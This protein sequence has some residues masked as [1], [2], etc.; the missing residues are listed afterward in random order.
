MVT[1][2]PES[3]LLDDAE[4]L[5]D[6]VVNEKYEREYRRGRGVVQ[7]VA[8]AVD[9]SAYAAKQ[10]RLSLGAVRRDLPF[11]LGVADGAQAMCP[12]L[13]VVIADDKRGRVISGGPC[14]GEGRDSGLVLYAPYEP[15]S[16]RWYVACAGCITSALGDADL[17]Y[18][19]RGVASGECMIGR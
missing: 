5:A 9:G 18:D 6:E 16:R 12:H 10:I 8:Y 19:Y 3:E 2:G 11:A 17:S 1:D 4:F 13:L 14:C 7:D 15:P